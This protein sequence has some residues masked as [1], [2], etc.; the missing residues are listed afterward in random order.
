MGFLKKFLA[1]VCVLVVLLGVRLARIKAF[2]TT[3]PPAGS[4]FFVVCFF[5]FF[6]SL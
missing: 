6:F 3:A 4:I 5:L 2:R 1:V